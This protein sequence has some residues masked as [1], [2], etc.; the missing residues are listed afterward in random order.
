MAVFN[1]LIIFYGLLFP[2]EAFIP[3]YYGKAIDSIVVQQSMDHFAK[4]VLTLAALALARSV[5][6]FVLCLFKD[7]WKELSI[8]IL[9]VRCNSKGTSHGFC[10]TLYVCFC[11]I[12]KYKEC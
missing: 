5:E 3:Y 9:K 6:I 4:P 12:D 2:G 10:G 8:C 1:P 7:L 11:N